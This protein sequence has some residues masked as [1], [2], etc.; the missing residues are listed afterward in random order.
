MASTTSLVTFSLITMSV[1]GIHNILGHIFI[2]N[3]VGQWHPQ[4]SSVN[5][6]HNMVTFSLITNVSVNGIHNILGHIFIDNNVGQ[7]HP[8]HPWSHGF[9]LITIR[10]MASTTS[11]VTFSLNNNVGQSSTMPGIIDNNVGQWHPPWCFH[12]NNGQWHLQ[13]P[14]CRSHPWSHFH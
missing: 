6:I 12:D 10:S 4:F 2:D 3:N 14:Q 5:G 7:W 1:N 8:Q 9:S 11:L 13:H